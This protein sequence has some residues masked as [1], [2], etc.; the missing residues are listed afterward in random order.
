MQS[1]DVTPSEIDDLLAVADYV[2]IH[3]PL[4]NETYHLIDERRLN[5]MKASAILINTA[6]GSLIDEP[7]LIRVLT[8]RKIG[9]AGLDVFEKEPPDK[10]NPLFFLHN[11]ILT[12]HC[13]SH[14]ELASQKV[15]PAAVDAVVRVLRGGYPTHVVNPEVLKWVA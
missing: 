8:E 10:N 11:V 9:G 13:A 1:D 12:P 15:R 4:T 14:T 3:S 2:S 5:L 6:R 7:A